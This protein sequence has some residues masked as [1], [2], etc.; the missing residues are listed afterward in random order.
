MTNY[1]DFQNGD[2]VVFDTSLDDIYIAMIIVIIMLGM[3]AG[4]CIFRNLR[5]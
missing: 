1:F 2:F 4:A 5:K 3:I